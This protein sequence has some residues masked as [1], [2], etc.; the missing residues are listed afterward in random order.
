MASPVWPHSIK[1]QCFTL[2]HP[3]AGVQL[4]L[5][6]DLATF[7]SF[8]YVHVG[9]WTLLFWQ[10]NWLCCEISFAGLRSFWLTR[11]S[12]LFLLSRRNLRSVCIALDL[13][14]CQLNCKI[15]QNK[16]GKIY[17]W[18]YICGLKEKNVDFA[19]TRTNERT[20]ARALASS[21]TLYAEDERCVL[22]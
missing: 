3:S 7:R 13:R 12:R 1:L 6:S 15:N 5:R 8:S 14:L 19:K 16:V 2:F 9:I 17:H 11:H 18:Q 10:K 21:S 20:N 4:T 22:C